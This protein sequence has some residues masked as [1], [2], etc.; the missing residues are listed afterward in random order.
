[1]SCGVQDMHR[2]GRKHKGPMGK[3]WFAGGQAGYAG[4]SQID[5]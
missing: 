1:M 2:A 3:P 4:T 5:V